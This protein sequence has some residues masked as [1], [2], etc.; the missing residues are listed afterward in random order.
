MFLFHNIQCR[1]PLVFCERNASNLPDDQL[2]SLVSV[3]Q[4]DEDVQQV[5][6]GHR[7][8]PG[9]SAVGWTV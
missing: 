2:Q 8:E 5:Q 4:R 6:L 3:S 7:P 1:L 9:H